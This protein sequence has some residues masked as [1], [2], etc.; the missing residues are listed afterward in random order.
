MDLATLMFVSYRAM[1]ER[2]LQAMR[3]AGYDVTVAQARLAQRIA[4]DGSRLTE[5]RSGNIRFLPSSA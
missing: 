1:D 3:E 4:D 2:V 5:R